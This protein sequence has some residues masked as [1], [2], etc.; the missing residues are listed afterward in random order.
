MYFNR[1]INTCPKFI[2]DGMEEHTIEFIV[3]VIGWI[4]TVMILL[5]YWM[6]TSERVT[7]K[8]IV[9]QLLNAFGSIGILI[10]AYY[11]GAMPSVGLNMIWLGIAVFGLVKHK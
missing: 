3:D 7:A 2:K 10:N 5:A 6:I 8:S 4:G 11:F 9:Y 1:L